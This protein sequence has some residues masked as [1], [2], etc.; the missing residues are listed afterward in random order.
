[1]LLVFGAGSVA[2]CPPENK[3]AP[4]VQRT[5]GSWYHLLVQRRPYRGHPAAVHSVALFALYR[6]HP[7]LLADD[8][9]ADEPDPAFSLWPEFSVQARVALLLPVTAVDD[10]FSSDRSCCDR[11][12]AVRALRSAHVL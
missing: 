1:V 3:T 9:R 2:T 6:A 7:S 12:P 11:I 10:E 5:T 8:F 4:I